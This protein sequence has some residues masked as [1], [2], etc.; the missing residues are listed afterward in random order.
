M[1]LNRSA[2]RKSTSPFQ[3]TCAISPEIDDAV[4]KSIPSVADTRPELKLQGE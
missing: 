1:P 4:G 3:W 2:L